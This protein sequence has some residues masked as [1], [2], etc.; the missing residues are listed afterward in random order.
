MQCFHVIYCIKSLYLFF[1]LG[2]SYFFIA[3]LQKFLKADSSSPSF[4]KLSQGLLSCIWTSKEWMMN[5]YYSFVLFIIIALSLFMYVKFKRLSI[6]EEITNRGS[7]RIT[8][9][10]TG[11]CKR[12]NLLYLCGNVYCFITETLLRR[13]NIVLWMLCNNQCPGTSSTLLEKIL[14]QLMKIH[15]LI[16]AASGPHI[17]E[18][19][20]FPL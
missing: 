12:N 3:S 5:Y 13:I 10:Q 1:F 16:F 4:S 20:R 7:N 14:S 15:C 18:T 17:R 19:W 9:N 8:T 6:P 11:Q 2:C